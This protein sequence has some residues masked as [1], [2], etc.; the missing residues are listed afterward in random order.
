MG[1]VAV[2]FVDHYL[3]ESSKSQPPASIA[4]SNKQWVGTCL[5]QE[6]YKPLLISCEAAIRLWASSEADCEY[7]LWLKYGITNRPVFIVFTVFPVNI[8]IKDYF[9]IILNWTYNHSITIL[10]EQQ[11][12]LLFT[13]IGTWYA[14]NL[15]F[16]PF[17]SVP[18]RILYGN[19]YCKTCKKRW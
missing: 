19:D 11:D 2:F 17:I 16:L 15:H 3:T 18:E 4:W 6:W 13:V 8:V 9:D 5:Y 7:P 14:D 10:A 12:F 1:I